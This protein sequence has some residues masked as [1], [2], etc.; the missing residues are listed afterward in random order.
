[1]GTGGEEPLQGA[2]GITQV[3]KTAETFY[4]STCAFSGSFQEMVWDGISRTNLQ[5]VQVS[6]KC[7]CKGW[8]GNGQDSALVFSFHS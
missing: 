4:L 2:A 7:G 5:K 6:G 1:M 8:G 3:R